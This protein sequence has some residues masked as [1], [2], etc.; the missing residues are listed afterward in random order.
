MFSAH[1]FDGEPFAAA[2]PHFWRVYGLLHS[3][4]R[5]SLPTQSRNILADMRKLF[6]RMGDS[7]LIEKQLPIEKGNSRELFS[8]CKKRDSCA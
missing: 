8:K 7:E 4:L 6:L 5:K 1:I 2:L 3:F